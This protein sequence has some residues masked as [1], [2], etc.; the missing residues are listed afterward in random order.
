MPKVTAAHL[1]GRRQQVL[2]A[3]FECFS[4]TG[5]HQTTM[6]DICKKAQLSPGAVYR[7]FSSKEAIIEAMVEQSR[8]QSTALIEE[9][10]GQGSTLQVLTNLADAFFGLLDQPVAQATIRL[11]MELWAEAL[12]NTQVMDLLRTDFKSIHRTIADIVRRGQDR[13]DVNPALD[14]DAVARVLMS[15]FDGLLIQKAMDPEVDVWK[16]VMVVKAMGAG[17]LW[18]YQAVEGENSGAALAR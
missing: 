18:Q 5:F 11:H 9:A 12:H 4:T 7:Y 13:G 10:K 14:P 16:Y 8:E 17:L 1:E 6:Q 3:A 15:F 2:N